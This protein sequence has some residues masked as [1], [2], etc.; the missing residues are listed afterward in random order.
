MVK[1]LAKHLGKIAGLGKKVIKFEKR[2]ADK[3][4]WAIAKKY[5]SDAINDLDDKNKAY[6][7]EPGLQAN[8]A[9]V[10]SQQ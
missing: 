10:A 4:T 7:M 9:D 8:T 5:F 6:G 1:Q 2:D 3:R